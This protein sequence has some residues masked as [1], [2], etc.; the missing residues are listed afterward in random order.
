LP[1]V[2]GGCCLQANTPKFKCAMV[3]SL[4]LWY[5]YCIFRSKVGIRFERA[6]STFNFSYGIVCIPDY[7][8][9]FHVHTGSDEIGAKVVTGLFLFFGV[10][11]PRH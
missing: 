6:K 8:L 2:D 4:L 7:D 9:V 1:L 11:R 5:G 3:A 10:L